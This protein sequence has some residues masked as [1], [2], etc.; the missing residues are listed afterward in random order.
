MLHQLPTGQKTSTTELRNHA[1]QILLSTAIELDHALSNSKK[2]TPIKGFIEQDVRKNT[3]AGEH[4]LVRMDQGFDINE[5]IA[6]FRALRKSVTRLFNNAS[7]QK[8]S[9][10]HNDLD[11]FNDI[12][13]QELSEAVVLYSFAKDQQTRLFDSMLSTSP[14]LSYIVDLDGTFQYVNRAMRKLYKKSSYEI[15]GK[16]LYNIEMPSAGDM[17]DHI[18][19]IIETGK[20]IKG[21]VSFKSPSGEINFFEYVLAPVFDASGKI[22]AIA[23]TSRDITEQKIA[24]NKTWKNANYDF[25]TGLPNRLMF[26]DKLEQAIIYSK[27][28]SE[29]FALLFIDLDKFKK[30]N[31]TLGHDLGDRLL[32]Q[33]AKRI[34]ASV[35]ETDIVARMGGDEFIVVL[36]YVRDVEEIKIVVENLMSKLSKPFKLNHKTASVSASIG[37]ALCPQDDVQSDGLLKKADKAMYLAKKRGR[38]QF[39]F[40]SKESPG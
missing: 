32:K 4:G 23:G 30:I 40:Y 37:I 16:A 18:Q 14:I 39:S 33:T 38:N 8:Q 5:V 3:P 25:L 1:K 9:F 28:A 10:D 13:D 11:F 35:R 27:R 34:N 15:L 17:R 6:E 20:K 21:E 22:E 31:D 26:R 24:E 7:N 36:T 19:S 12:I 2:T 29:S